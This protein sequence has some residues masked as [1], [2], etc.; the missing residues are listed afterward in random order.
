[1]A[2]QLESFLSKFSES[3]WLSAAEALA[4]SV[5]PVDRNAFRIWLRFYPLSLNRHLE[6]VENKAEAMHKMAFQGEYGLSDK[7]DSSH[8]FLYGHRYWGTVKT[9]IEGLMGSF[10][11]S[12]DLG[13]TIER[14]A[15]ETASKAG[16][17]K[18][19]TLG[20]ATVGL[21]T[22]AQVGGDAFK[23]AKGD[24]E[25]PSGLMAKSPD[26]IVAERHRDDSQGMF[27]F[28]KSVDKKFTVSW[29]DSSAEGSF[30]ITNDA[31]I[32]TAADLDRSQDWRS[33]DSRCWEGVV[34]VECRSA[35]CGLCWVG[36]LGGE[37]KLSE[38]QRLE[39]KQMKVFGYQQP[40]EPKPYLRLAC[41]AKAYGNS[42]IVIPPWNGVF[43]RKVYGVEDSKLEPATTS[44][45]KLRETLAAVTEGDGGS[46]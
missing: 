22:L 4:P 39:R 17:D 6:S 34:P 19:L 35:A 29:C 3:D 44:A 45:R 43:G 2:T 15:A 12:G 37:E 28:L 11:G 38:V 21:M 8:R 16:V 24:S 30:R 5:H 25:K 32:A 23:A 33:R 40:D 10:D 41:Q 18:A 7:I 31:D 46:E 27:S 14:I 20:I 26:A 42:S 13:G 9:V 36:V 1:M